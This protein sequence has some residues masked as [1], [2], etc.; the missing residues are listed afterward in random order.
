[1]RRVNLK[2]LLSNPRGFC[3]GVV[4]AIDI[5]ELALKKL[6]PP[7]YVK[8]Q[9]VHN[10]F[11]VQDLESKGAITVENVSD[12]P[13]H[14][15]V[16][17]SAHGSQPE[18]YNNAKQKGLNIIDATCPLVTKVHNEAKKYSAQKRK[19]IL[20]GHEGHQEVKGTM[21]QENMHLVDDR[22]KLDFPQWEKSSP[23]TVLTQTT[24]SV[25]DTQNSIS[26]IQEKFSD[27]IVRNDLCYAT[28]N[29]QEAIKTIAKQ[30]ELVLVIGAPNSSNCNRLR[31][32][33]QSFGIPAYLINTPA[34]IDSNWF[35][36]VEIIG[37]TSGASTP[38]I[39]VKN[40][41]EFL[42]PEEVETVQGAHEDVLFTLPNKLI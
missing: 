24:L 38:E 29:R 14:C 16:V 8:H 33:A 39:L 19:L 27:V 36:D 2:V 32:V 3:A 15:N 1:M 37:V 23:I 5:V 21:G 9:I 28:T 41:I 4:R 25:D 26:K 31:E 35:N 12:I 40:V 22:Q 34:E 17:F 42:A 18:D 11:V 10:P 20:I 13:D 30:V 7:I 6:G